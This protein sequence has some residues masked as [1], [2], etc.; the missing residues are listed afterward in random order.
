M[1]SPH[2]FEYLSALALIASSLTAVPAATAQTV[3]SNETLV[4]TTFVVNTKDAKAICR[5]ADCV[6]KT[7]MFAPIQVTC[8]AATGK[9]CTFHIFLDAKASVGGFCNLCQPA[10]VDYFQFL[11]DDAAP[12]IGPTD[13]Q[14][15]YR[16]AQ[17]IVGIVSNEIR[18]SFPASVVTTVTNSS[19]NNHTVALNIACRSNPGEGGCETTAHASTL[20]VDVFEP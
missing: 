16:F 11:V 19:S 4:A 13:A 17:N 6:A 8:P 3:I 20:R 5:H 10:G 1:K 2:I 12:T 15:F 18:Q 14:G 9:T 7:A